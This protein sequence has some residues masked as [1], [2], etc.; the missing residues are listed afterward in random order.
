V[1]LDTWEGMACCSG[2]QRVGSSL[3][4]QQH[5]VT[6]SVIASIVW[7][8]LRLDVKSREECRL[9]QTLHRAAKRNSPL[10][11]NAVLAVP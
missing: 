8:G 11:P 1:C 9:I 2:C 7:A 5:K 4:I 3:R 6:R 10:Q